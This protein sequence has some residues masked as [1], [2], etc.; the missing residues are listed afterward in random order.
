[1]SNLTKV[2]IVL[3]VVFSI[4]F[5]TMT[6]SMVAQTTDWRDTALKYEEH[7]RVADTNL[8]NMIAASAAVEA[9]GR[10]TARGH[11]ER[12]TEL[13]GQ[14]AANSS[15]LARIRADLAKAES[16]QS[17][18]EA[19]N[20]GLLAQLEIARAAE[21]EYRKRRDDIEKRG[22][23]L[24]RRNIDLNDRVN[25]LT[26]QVSVLVE[27]RRQYEQQIN[28]LRTENEK[29][30]QAEQRRPAAAGLEAPAGAA[31]QNV[32][33]LSPA[34]SAAITGQVLAVSGNLVTISVGRAA[35]V[36]EDMLF[37]IHRGGAYVGDLKIDKVD[38]DQAA[39]RVVRSSGTPTRGDQ[40]TDALAMAGSRG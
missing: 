4:A 35:G 10:D 11:L 38:P 16:E 20:R 27:Q 9:T 2:F 1:M 17:S 24:E 19:M 3:L 12:I 34:G 36:R 26:A 28:I 40:V 21:S 23:D 7:A 5:S 32:V 22:I 25:E 29:L 13:E 14:L 15:E 8:R 37:V 39:G 31:M 6:V 30:S 18:S 33:P